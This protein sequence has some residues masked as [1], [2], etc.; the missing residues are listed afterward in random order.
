VTSPVRSRVLVVEDDIQI[1]RFLRAGLEAS[2]YE[3]DHAESGEEGVA[4]VARKPPDVVILDLGLPDIDGVEVVRRIREWSTVPIVVLSARSQEAEKIRALDAGADDYVTKPVGMGELL[5]RIR[6]ALRRARPSNAQESSL[7]SW[8][9][10]QMD[11][12]AHR[13]TRSD[14]EIHLT[15]TEFRLLAV[16]ARNADKVVTQRQLLQEVWGAAY[17]ER[18]HYLRIHMAAIRQKL[19]QEPSRPR[20]LLTET[21]VGYRLDTRTDATRR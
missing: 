4:Q 9:D 5:A 15:P 20:Y 19:E 18:A 3:L 16:L 12:A 1:R 2:G 11:L 10:V 14:R 21:G 17:V 13:V 6:V 7:L 8:C